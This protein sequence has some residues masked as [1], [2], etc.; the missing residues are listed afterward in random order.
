[1]ARTN[2]KNTENIFQPNQNIEW[3][4]KKTVPDWQRWLEQGKVPLT[5]L[6]RLLKKTFL[7]LEQKEPFW[8]LRLGI[9]WKGELSPN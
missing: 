4:A 2:Q 6:E 8:C 5:K 7:L 3:A 9:S 1:M